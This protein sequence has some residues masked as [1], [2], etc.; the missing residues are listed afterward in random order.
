ME[1]I[2]KKIAIELLYETYKG[3]DNICNLYNKKVS[4][5]F[6]NIGEDS[7][8]DAVDYL[9]MNHL[10][11]E[12]NK[13]CIQLEEKGKEVIEEFNGDIDAY[14]RKVKEIK[15][16]QE[17]LLVLQV[18]EIKRTK[19]FSIIAVIISFIGLGISLLTLLK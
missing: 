4:S 1:Q 18:K 8:S 16:K 11:S 2:I 3:R 10:V 19:I 7:L 13:H 9:K 14:L 12:V 17:E 6:E 5:N 15:N